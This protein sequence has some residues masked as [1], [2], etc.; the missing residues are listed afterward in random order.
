MLLFSSERMNLIG[1][2]QLYP[3]C[4]IAYFD[5]IF[6]NFLL[7]VLVLLASLTPFYVPFQLQFSSDFNSTIFMLT[8]CKL[9]NLRYPHILFI[10]LI[11]SDFN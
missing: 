1:K 7:L 9:L 10:F 8:V 6:I 4:R 3:M 11:L 5:P 2:T